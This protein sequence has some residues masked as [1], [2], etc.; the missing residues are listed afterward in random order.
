L[1]QKYKDDPA[2]GR[3]IF[4]YNAHTAYKQG[5]GVCR[6]DPVSNYHYLHPDLTWNP[7]LCHVFDTL[8][9]AC[10]CIDQYI[11]KATGA[12]YMGQQYDFGICPENG[13][14]MVIY[15]SKSKKH[16]EGW[17]IAR[18]QEG[19][20]GYLTTDNQWVGAEV[21]NLPTKEKAEERVKEY[22]RVVVETATHAYQIDQSNMRVRFKCPNCSLLHVTEI[23]SSNWKSVKQVIRRKC[24]KGG[25]PVGYIIRLWLA[26]QSQPTGKPAKIDKLPV[27]ECKECW[28]TGEYVGFRDAEPCTTCFGKK[29]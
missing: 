15:E 5:V 17:G 23:Q 25:D 9:D 28:G 24:P 6:P 26:D 22:M 10:R 21:F 7:T 27:Y 13:Q 16:G 2:T 8:V 14:K 12:P 18:S 29:S 1:D 19:G 11:A 20:Y 4:T 3:G